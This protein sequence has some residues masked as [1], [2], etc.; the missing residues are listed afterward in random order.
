[1]DDLAEHRARRW[2]LLV[3]RECWPE[4]TH[5]ATIVNACMGFIPTASAA[6]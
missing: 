2:F 5:D 3:C 1:V 6:L 4:A